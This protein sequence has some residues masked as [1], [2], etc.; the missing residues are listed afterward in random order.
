MLEIRE[1]ADDNQEAIPATE[2]NAELEVPA[3][4]HQN[5]SHEIEFVLGGGGFVVLREPWLSSPG[6]L[7]LNEGEVHV[8][9]A[10]LDSDSATAE[11]YWATLSEDERDRARRFH[12]ERDRRRF[13]AAR[14]KL[15]DMLGRYLGRQPAQIRFTYNSYGKPSL[16]GDERD[17]LRFNASHSYGAGLYAFKLRGEVGVDIEEL[18]DDFASLDVAE[19]F[20]SKSEV[21]VLGSLPAHIRTQ[22]FFNCWTRKEAYIKALGEGLSHPLDRFT[23]SLTP[24]ESARLISTDTDASEASEWTIIDLKPFRGF[25]AALAVK[26]TNLKLYCWDSS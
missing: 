26:G 25:A 6:R 17:R 22:G 24:G 7:R 9:R 1:W 18:R 11:R 23:V 4:S 16:A 13:V 15:R 3:L 10:S 5:R 12:F 2:P 20:F 14:G 21:R 8:W 19:R